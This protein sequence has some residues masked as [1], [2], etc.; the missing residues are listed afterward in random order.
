MISLTKKISKAEAVYKNSVDATVA[1]ALRCWQAYRFLEPQSEMRIFLQR[2]NHA[3]IA[4]HRKNS[5]HIKLYALTIFIAIEAGH[6][7]SANGMLDKAMAYKNFLKVN[8]PKF[9]GELCF[10][11]AYLEINQKRVRSAKKHSRAL[12]DHVKTAPPSPYYGVMTGL[13]HLAAE[14]FPEAYKYL[15]EAF[16]A[17]VRSVFLYEGLYRYYKNVNGGFEGVNILPVLLYAAQRGA[18]ISAVAVKYTDTLSAAVIADPQIGEKLYA[19]SGYP[20]ILKDICSERIKK[21]DMSP[22]AFAFYRDAEKKQIYTPALFGALIRAA[23][24][25]KALKVNHYPIKKFFAAT[26]GTDSELFRCN[27]NI[28]DT[29]FAVFVYHFL[30]TDPALCDLLPEAEER[31]FELGTRCLEEKITGREANTIYYFMWKNYR[32]PLAEAFLQ[33]N[34]TQFELRARENS[35]VRFVYIT[36]P[37]KRG[38][39][40]YELSEPCVTIEAVHENVSY[41]CLGATRRIIDEELTITPMIEQA[42]VELYFYFFQKG[43][44]RFYLLVYLANYFLE[45]DAPPPEAAPVFDALLA[46]KSI[47]KAYRMKILVALGRLHYNAG[48]FK[49]ALECFAQVDEAAINDDFIAHLLSVYIQTREFERAAKLISAK[50][51]LIPNKFLFEAVS[52]LITHCEDICYVSV[53]ETGYHLLLNGFFSEELLAFVLKNFDASY[54]EWA[55]LSQATDEDNRDAQMLD[56]RVLEAALLISAFDQQSQ[57]SFSRLFLAEKDSPLLAEFVELATYEMLAN[58]ARPHYDVLNILEKWYPSNKSALLAW[59]LG[60]TFLRYNITT[61]KSDEIIADAVAAMENEGILF[62]VFKENFSSPFIEKFQPFLYKSQPDKTC[63]LHYRIDDAAAFSSIPMQYI[64]YGLY[65]V[66]VPMFYNEAFTY[67]FSEEHPSGSITTKQLTVKNTKQF[68][69]ESPDPYFAINNAIINE[70]RF[71]HDQV[72]KLITGLVKDT[73]PVRAGIL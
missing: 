31:I 38:M 63:H 34:L 14:E 29:G 32:T 67:Y 40:V 18:D 70:S 65:V 16:D 69:Y 1:L 51:K 36:Q 49:S 66:A 73:Q 55:Q 37:E 45:L 46:E 64:R 43:D 22:K 30:L 27:N 56:E 59:A 10:L 7:D 9:F 33:I 5:A 11:Y 61:F 17:G 60:G 48:N 3:V 12:A 71:K 53:A 44:R 47:T 26:G 39:S 6:Y 4:A 42:D 13:L 57:K 54:S 25:N 35:A 62:P 58:A 8:E 68:I 2:A 50:Q 41:T 15:S 52:V 20:P 23:Y 21:G 28:N 72:E 24:E 19:I